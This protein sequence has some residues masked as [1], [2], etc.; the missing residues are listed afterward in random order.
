[1]EP[2]SARLETTMSYS[3]K[4]MPLHRQKPVTITWRAIR[5]PTDSTITIIT[6]CVTA[7]TDN[8]SNDNND[9]TG[10]R[11]NE[12]RGGGSADGGAGGHG[13]D[14]DGQR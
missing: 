4:K 1:M 12:D 9:D 3:R 13:G 14:G 10:G 7:R 8:T 2:S 5:A 11:H 6:F